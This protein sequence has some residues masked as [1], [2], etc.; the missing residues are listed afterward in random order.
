MKKMMFVVLSVAFTNA[1]GMNLEGI[2]RESRVIFDKICDSPIPRS[3]KFDAQDKIQIDLSTHEGRRQL[4]CIR[5]TNSFRPIDF[6]VKISKTWN[7]TA[8]CARKQDFALKNPDSTYPYVYKGT[9]RP[10][11]YI[12]DYKDQLNEYN[13]PRGG[14]SYNFLL[15]GFTQPDEWRLLGKQ[16]ADFLM[17]KTPKQLTEQT[18]K[19]IGLLMSSEYMRG[20]QAL[21]V[22]RMGHLYLKWHPENFNN[23]NDYKEI[24][25][26]PKNGGSVEIMEYS[27]DQ[28][29]KKFEALWKQ[30]PYSSKVASLPKEIQ[31]ML[32][33]DFLIR[34]LNKIK[35]IYCDF[36]DEDFSLT[37]HIR[38]KFKD[39][40]NRMIS[41]QDTSVRILRE[42]SG[43]EIESEPELESELDYFD[44]LDPAAEG[45]HEDVEFRNGKSLWELEEEYRFRL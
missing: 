13:V 42:V 25:V 11:N 23:C 24:M 12:F 17:F 36:W 15:R 29:G 10:I 33:V 5:E 18:E 6:F 27:K 39:V 2:L 31:E 1:E 7:V 4:R 40:V 38:G 44:P 16:V 34:Q 26:Y 41:E 45:H 22:A 20:R 9:I 21:A 35:M 28:M 8:G 32:K 43:S 19:L 3:A 14:D 37:A 30:S